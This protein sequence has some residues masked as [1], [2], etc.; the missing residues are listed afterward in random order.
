MN[1]KIGCCGF[2][3]AKEKYYQHF[4]V[5]ELQQTF[6]QPPQV[7]TAKR[8]KEEAPRDLEFTLKAWQL[9]THQ[10]SSPTY[11]RLSEKISSRRQKFLGYFQPTDEVFSAW[12]KIDEIAKASGAKTIVFQ[13]PASFTPTTQH[14]KNLR[15]FFSKIKRDHYTLVWEPRGSWRQEEINELCDELQLRACLDPF[16]KHSQ[17]RPLGYFRLHG[18]G[19]H[20]YR[21]NKKDLIYL[22]ELS[23]KFRQSY[24]MFNNISMYED[25]KRFLKFLKDG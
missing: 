11:R 12:E 16:L 13:C 2:P 22:N 7:K 18:K 24:F 17:A 8:W 15:R 6:Y 21:Y 19:S 10:P 20:R 14:K 5:V 25:A 3:L 4:K 9:I 1:I 23:E